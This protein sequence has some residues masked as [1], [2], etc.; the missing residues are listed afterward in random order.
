VEINNNAVVVLEKIPNE[1][2]YSSQ[3]SSQWSSSERLTESQSQVNI[4]M[5]IVVFYVVHVTRTNR[6][7]L[8]NK[9]PNK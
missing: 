5:F 3:T 7:S 8:F 6:I 1:S 2:E 4:T 9:C